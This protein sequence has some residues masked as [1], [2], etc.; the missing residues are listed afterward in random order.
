MPNHVT[1]A[2]D[3]IEQRANFGMVRYASC[4]EDA[5]VLLEALQAGPGKRVLSIAAAGDNVFA[6]LAT[7]AAVVAADISAA[8]LACLELKRAAFISLNYEDMLAFVG[9]NPTTERRRVYRELAHHLSSNACRFWDQHPQ[10]VADGIIHH[11][12]FEAYFRL[13]RQRVLPWIHSRRRIAALFESR[14]RAERIAFWNDRWNNWRWRALLRI[15]F[16]RY[17]MGKLG[18]D[19]EF[20]RYVTGSIG[21]LIQ[22]R[23]MYAMTELE[24][25]GNPYLQ[26]IARGN[27]GPSLPFYL[28]PEN[29]VAIREGMHRLRWYQGPIEVIAK[30]HQEGGYH[31]MNL[32]D[33]FEYVSEQTTEAM[34][35]ELLSVSAP[36]ARIAYWNTFVPRRCHVSLYDRVRPLEE[37]SSALHAK[38]KAFFYTHFQVDEVVA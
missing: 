6:I 35:R 11:G 19:P 23:V 5:D 4:W 34:Y 21:D 3:S 25:A 22:A 18:R 8:Q 36:G 20:F 16:S 14:D 1:S 17:L 33:I 27:Y 12:K 32:S 26:Y 2:P 24:P 30:Q 7:G 31:A 15:F 9:V 38:D 28:R 13:F 10:A 29:F 37:L